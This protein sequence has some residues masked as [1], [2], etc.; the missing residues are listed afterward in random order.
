M[1]QAIV[2]AVS[3]AII[4]VSSLVEF[5]LGE[6]S[7]A[8]QERRARVLA[9]LEESRADALADVEGARGRFY[10]VLFEEAATLR[11]RAERLRET[12]RKRLEAVQ[13]ELHSQTRRSTEETATLRAEEFA[14]QRTCDRLRA[15]AR[16]Y[17]E[18]CRRQWRLKQAH[19]KLAA[20]LPSHTLPRD[21]PYVGKIVSV[22]RSAAAKG[23]V[24]LGYGETAE[25]IDPAVAA[26]SRRK[27]VQ[28]AV[29]GVRA[30]PFR[31]VASAEHGGL[32]ELWATG[33]RF[34]A[35]ITEALTTGELVVARHA[36]RL[37]LPLA[38]RRHPGRR[39]SVGAELSVHL[40]DFDA[41]W[42]RVTVTELAERER[43]RRRVPITLAAGG[44]A[45]RSLR[46]LAPELL[47]S[48]PTRFRASAGNATGREL[49]LD[50]EQ[51]GARVAVN[52]EAGVLEVLE[53]LH[54]ARRLPTRAPAAYAVTRA[55][56]LAGERST[57]SRTAVGALLGE[58]AAAESRSEELARLEAA[59]AFDACG[60]WKDLLEDALRRERASGAVPLRISGIEP[61][62]AVARLQLAEPLD[63]EV[64]LSRAELGD[65]DLRVVATGERRT[66]VDVAVPPGELLPEP[67]V[68]GLGIP[69]P[70]TPYLRQIEALEA[71]EHGRVVA[72]EIRHTL[73]DPAQSPK[74]LRTRTA[75]RAV[76]LDP[77]QREAL[78]R[79]ETARGV[80]AL[81][82]P[83][84]AGKT[85]FIA[86]AVERLLARDPDARVLVASQSNVAVDQVLTKLV[87]GAGARLTRIGAPEKVLQEVSGLLVDRQL[88]AWRTA[89]GSAG[90]TPA[91][92]RWRQILRRSPDAELDAWL[93]GRNVIGATCI[94]LA[95]A[96]WGIGTQTFD[97]VIVDEA[98]RATFPELLV[99]LNR[100]RRALVVGDPFQLPP[101]VDEAM[102]DGRDG[103]DRATMHE[104]LGASYFAQ[105][106]AAL[107]DANRAMLGLQYRM[108][109]GISSVVSRL[110][111]DGRLGDG[112][113]AG[114]ESARAWPDH[115]LW[116]DT[117]AA[118]FRAERDEA[119]SLRNRGELTVALAWLEALARRVERASRARAAT[120]FLM[121]PYRAQK[122]LALAE[123]SRR[124]WPGLAVLVRTVDEVQGQE[125]DFV[126]FTGTRTGGNVDF[127]ADRYRMNV[128]LSRA[129]EAFVL[130]GHAEGLARP[131]NPFAGLREILGEGRGGHRLVAWREGLWS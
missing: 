125:A 12:L 79:F 104:F 122:A 128:A 103:E 53:V 110:F 105:L 95:S 114:S 42:S 14:L 3:A 69:N 8:E 72:E 26:A 101:V 6:Q 131:G 54:G 115:V 29:V 116:V 20:E 87:G 82:G 77:S 126:V 121:T 81:L 90:D 57:G 129:R 93:D 51:V 45:A 83:P 111:Y 89:L 120:V 1:I 64:K 55:V 48:A 96:R 43:S 62:G 130:V 97:L 35:A 85:R 70:S 36:A 40:R 117:S 78:K 59:G 16:G 11:E 21:Y 13:A 119:G 32:A 107:P 27:L 33:A 25:I 4:V 44:G 58:L 71:F 61:R 23:H 86:T 108:A 50:F 91:R 66:H 67:P 113:D 73:L 17:L 15:Y 39:L 30:E 88:A 106:Y 99:P 63:E 28:V 56:V 5:L 60:Q 49:I 102:L 9:R 34:D 38:E 80:F 112:R 127:V 22:P 31:Y 37:R 65:L 118:G 24:S 109:S 41:R 19:R 52:A 124:N 76:E 2:L 10:D 92:A 7:K 123:V 46:D 47:G 98:G 74:P 75:A 18:W 94:G 84:G 100:A 68:T